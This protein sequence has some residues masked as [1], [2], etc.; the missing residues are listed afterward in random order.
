MVMQ[1][2]SHILFT[3]IHSFIHLHSSIP[4]VIRH[5]S[6]VMLIQV[7]ASGFQ[8]QQTC[9]I[10]SNNTPSWPAPPL[11][12]Q[13]PWKHGRRSYSSAERGVS[14]SSMA[15]APLRL[16][17][18]C[19]RKRTVSFMSVQGL[20]SAPTMIASSRTCRASQETLFPGMK[21]LTG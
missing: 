12:L 17:T 8:Q 15:S 6:F 20:S 10:A 21:K 13:S 5:S 2:V 9:N 11:A 3:V 1:C 7:V 14:W 4:F 16:P 18:S 19:L